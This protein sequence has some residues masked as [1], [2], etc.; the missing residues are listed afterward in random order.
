MNVG[1]VRR[2]T[3]R[4]MGVTNGEILENLDLVELY[5]NPQYAC[6]LTGLEASVNRALARMRALGAL[7][8]SSTTLAAPVVTGT[9][10]TYDL[11][12]VERLDE[13]LDLWEKTEDGYAAHPYR[14][15]G[16]DL[17]VPFYSSEA[18]YVLTYRET[19][20]LLEPMCADETELGVPSNLAVLIPYFVKSELTEEEDAVLAKRARDYFE[21]GVK[22]S[23]TSEENDMPRLRCTY[24]WEE[25]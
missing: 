22:A 17:V 9:V 21:Q 14:R 11:T 13:V 1:T 10:A 16:N 5:Q 12:A 3:L 7:R 6:Y 8:P 18:E 4:M 25:L 24:R 23:V 19:L 2:E 20:E 15:E